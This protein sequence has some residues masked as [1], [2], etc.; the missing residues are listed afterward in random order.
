MSKTPEEMAG[1]RFTVQDIRNWSPCY[2]PA[3]HLPEDWS[4][5]IADILR[6]ATIPA[7]DKLWVVCREGLIDVKTLR[8]FAVW[9]A[10]QVEH[11][12]T[13][14]RSK[15]ASVVAEKFAH[16]EATKLELAAAWAAAWDAARAAGDAARDAAR[17]AGD[18]AWDAARAAAGAAGDAAW[19]AARAAAGAARAAAGAAARAAAWDAAWAA[20][21]DAARAAAWDAA[22]DAQVKQLLKM[23]E[24]G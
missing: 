21:G 23:V 20:A 13:D 1:N 6:H 19:D 9:C 5:T 18:A 10:R 14:E 12:M 24:E 11:L 8:L 16:G 4:G 3:R 17:A 22:R 7:H 15:A 2:D